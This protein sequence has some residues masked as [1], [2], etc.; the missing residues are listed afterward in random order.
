MISTTIY[1]ELDGEV[2]RVNGRTHRASRELED[3]DKRMVSTLHHLECEQGARFN[4]P[5]FSKNDLKKIW[6][7]NKRNKP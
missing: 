2:V 3:F 6:I 1:K 5:G 7:D 4:V